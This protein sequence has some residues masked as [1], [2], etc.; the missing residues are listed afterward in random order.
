MVESELKEEN[1]LLD[2]RRDTEDRRVKDETP[3]IERRHVPDRR[4]HEDRRSVKTYSQIKRAILRELCEN[5]RISV[6]QLATKLQ[7]SRNTVISNMKALEK[8]FGLY[9]T[10]EFNKEALGFVQNHLWA[11]KLEGKPTLQ[12]L[13]EMFKN[14]DALPFILQTE[15]DFDLLINIVAGSGEKYVQSGMQTLKKLLPYRPTPRPSLVVM[16]HTG[17]IP[18][19]GSAIGNLNPQFSSLDEL[20][21]KILMQLNGNSRLNYNAIAKRLKEDVETIRY[22]MRKIIKLQII[23][24]FTT[25]LENPGTDYNIAFFMNC[26]FSPGLTGRYKKAYDYYISSNKDL[27]L[28]NNFQYLA[29]TSGSYIMAGIGCFPSEE[30]A[31]KDAIIAHKEIYREDRPTL[32]FAK[33]TGVVKGHLPVRSID[34]EKG[35]SQLKWDE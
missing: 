19:D 33:I 29:L 12:Q 18:V 10:L 27:P 5:S 2:D 17:F 9:Y 16:V 1:R 8:E 13:Q 35:F 31:I 26:K 21:I 28:I 11:I 4:L 7:C 32:T 6:T 24:R 23:K 22:R 34:M 14:D 3:I 20:D 15:G 25:V 30:K